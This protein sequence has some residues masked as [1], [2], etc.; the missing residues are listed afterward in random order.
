MR[1]EGQAEPG[2]VCVSDAVAAQVGGKLP[3]EF[4]EMGPLSLKNIDRP[5][6]AYKVVIPEERLRP[7]ARDVPA[8][9]RQHLANFGARPAIA[10]LP[11]VDLSGDGD[12]Q[13]YFADGL[14]EDI[15]VGLAGWH[16]LPVIARNSSFAFRRRRLASRTIG[17]KLGARYV[18]EGT[19]RRSASRVRIG[20]QLIETDSGEHVFAEHYDRAI[21]DIFD[22]QDAI[23][24]R[25]V[26]EVAPEVLRFERER[27]ARSPQLNLDAY[28]FYQR[29]LWHHY[30]YTREDAGKAEEFFRRALALDANYGP[31]AAGLATSIVHSGMSGWAGAERYREA[32]E[33]AGSAVALDPR[34]PQAHFALGVARY[35]QAQIEPALKDLAEAIRLDPSHAA[36]HANMGFLFNYLDRPTKALRSVRWAFRSEPRSIR[37]SSCGSRRSLGHITSRA[38]SRRRS[39][40]GSVGY[41]CGPTI[42]TRPAMWRRASDGSA[43]RRRPGTTSPSCGRSMAASKV[44]A[45][46]SAASQ[47]RPP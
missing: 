40:R 27:V 42:C 30:R 13:E 23:A 43:A 11:F 38:T 14:T 12:Q 21:G 2:G 26:G 18:L 6:R 1:L 7:S 41:A 20:A 35:H 33:L 17:A 28:D 3:L 10:V 39:R 44:R 24:R 47:T 36:A 29:G 45:P 37:A 19:V 25:I 32:E 16:A 5:V 31:A 22:V 15:I 46:R 34:D 9:P 8:K 4:E